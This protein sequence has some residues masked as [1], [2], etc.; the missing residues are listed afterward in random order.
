MKN[1]DLYE[2][3]RRQL[4]KDL[5]HLE[6]ALYRAETERKDPMILLS[7][8]IIYHVLIYLLK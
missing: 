3:K 7:L 1:K 6:G 8:R 4:I 5:D 2:H